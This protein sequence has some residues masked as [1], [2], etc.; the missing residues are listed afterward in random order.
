M[1]EVG[2][3]GG[4]AARS[5]HLR[6]GRATPGTGTWP[7]ARGK[8]KGEQQQRATAGSSLRKEGQQGGVTDR[9]SSCDKRDVS[10]G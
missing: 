8:K 10:T 7:S 5:R 2:E 9:G 4:S 3:H 1:P 6:R